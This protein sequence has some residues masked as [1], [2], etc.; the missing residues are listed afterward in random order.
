MAK[1]VE[2]GLLL[3]GEDAI[4]FRKY[5]EHP[6]FT[7]EGLNLMHETKHDQEHDGLEQP[8]P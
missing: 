7:K 2:I 4:A 3:E 6:T 8:L 5:L 1:P